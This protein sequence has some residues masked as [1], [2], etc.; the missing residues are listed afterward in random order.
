ML[1]S[2][3]GDQLFHKALRGEGDQV[4]DA[5]THADEP[6][7]QP[8]PLLDR[9]DAAA[10]GGAVELGQDDAGGIG[11]LAELLGLTDG[12][13]ARDG[14]QHQQ[15]LQTRLRGRLFDAA[16][17][18]G[19]LAHQVR[20]V[21]EAARRVGDD[22]IVAASR[23]RLDRVEDDSGRVCALSGLDQRHTCPVGPDLQLLAG[24]GAEGIARCQHDAAALPGVVIGQ[25]RDA[26]GLAHAVD[27]DDEDDGGMA[28]QLHL[29]F[30]AHLV[31]DQLPQLVG[32]F[33][34]G[35][36][37]LLLHAVPQLVHQFDGHFAAHV[38]QNELLFQ[39][40]VEVV[41][42][43][44]AGQRIEDVAPKARAGLFEAVLHLVFFF[45][46]KSKK[47]HVVYGLS[48]YLFASLPS[49]STSYGDDGEVS[50]IIPT[51]PASRQPVQGRAS[52]VSTR[53]PPA[54]SRR[55]GHWRPPWCRG[56]G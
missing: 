38:R 31:G 45:F 10:L 1:P 48:F 54:W 39:F 50:S 37:A 21:V 17:D 55:R 27:A 5:L 11:C 16:A 19:Q 4:V 42:D 15:R 51:K 26:G 18:L 29:G 53:R 8:Q 24:G 52:K 20:L 25:L 32:R 28:V 44:A 41:V 3:A 2:R 40:I 22:H 33:F 43:L 34:A 12:V 36:Q 7:R 46:T 56:G 23:G 49:P 47:S 35:L 6:H 13:L 30:G 9:H 14:V